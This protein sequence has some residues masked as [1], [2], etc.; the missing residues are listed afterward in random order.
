VGT[1][2]E[3]HRSP[4]TSW[5]WD[6]QLK[7]AQIQHKYGYTTEQIY[8]C[9]IPGRVAH[10]LFRIFAGE[11]VDGKLSRWKYPVVA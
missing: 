11:G 10:D 7:V 9:A 3:G 5:H 4:E 1:A 2:L 6:L 8:N